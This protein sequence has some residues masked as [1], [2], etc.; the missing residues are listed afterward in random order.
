MKI[1]GKRILKNGVTAGYVYY[2]NDKKWKWRFLK[3]PKKKNKQKGGNKVT[4]A[5]ILRELKN[6]LSNEELIFEN[7]HPLSDG[8]IVEIVLETLSNK[9]EINSNT[10]NRVRKILRKIRGNGRNAGNNKRNNA[11]GNNGGESKQRNMLSA[12]Q[13]MSLTKVET[14]GAGGSK[15]INIVKNSEGKEYAK[16]IIDLHD[17]SPI[18][19]K[20]IMNEIECLKLLKNEYIVDL[21][22]VYENN[23]RDELHVV[24]ELGRGD[25]TILNSGTDMKPIINNMLEALVFIH[26]M[27]VIHRDIKPKNFIVSIDNKIKLIDFGISSICSQNKK[28]VFRTNLLNRGEIPGTPTYFSPEAILGVRLN[29]KTYDSWALGLTIIEL[30]RLEENYENPWIG[31]DV[32]IFH[33]LQFPLAL[34]CSNVNSSGDPIYDANWNY[35]KKK[36]ELQNVMN[37]L[38]KDFGKIDDIFNKINEKYFNGYPVMQN[39]FT[40]QKERLTARDILGR[41]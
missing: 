9:Y 33:V 15:Q 3:G 17:L 39:I 35:E 18:S 5:N 30:F 23:S 41:M 1:K 21:L 8:D 37:A 36:R 16:Y 12:N 2:K 34:V 38:F 14:I 29:P 10:E 6:S 25:L 27:G 22:G 40:N 20:R 26:S 31:T 28:K 11:V 24:T 32:R 19:R 13:I 7:K 4:N